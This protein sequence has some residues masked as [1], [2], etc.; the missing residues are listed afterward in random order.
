MLN[1]KCSATVQSNPHE[2]QCFWFQCV[3]QEN[4]ESLCR[5]VLTR[6]DQIVQ[7]DVHATRPVRYL[8]FLDHIWS[9]CLHSTTAVFR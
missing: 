2:I 4:V 9:K 3:E 7:K 5:S 8:I 1:F 6:S